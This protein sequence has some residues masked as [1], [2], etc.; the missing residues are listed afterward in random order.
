M[1]I[2]PIINIP[3]PIVLKYSLGLVVSFIVNGIS[4]KSLRKK[5]PATHQKMIEPILN[6][7]SQFIVSPHI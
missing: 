7:N 4:K 1:K 6:V 3:M 2:D 5:I